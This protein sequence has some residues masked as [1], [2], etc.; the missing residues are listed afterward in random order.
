MFQEQT[1]SS[2]LIKN[3][4]NSNLKNY[5]YQLGSQSV[6]G[7]EGNFVL[8]FF[9]FDQPSQ[10]VFLFHSLRRLLPRDRSSKCKN[11]FCNR[12]KFTPRLSPV[13]FVRQLLRKK[14]QFVKCSLTK[15]CAITT[16][17][18]LLDQEQ[19]KK[20][21]KQTN[22]ERLIEIWKKTNIE[23]LHLTPVLLPS[24]NT[25]MRPIMSSYLNQDHI[26]SSFPMKS[27][28]RLEGPDRK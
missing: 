11:F 16:R 19:E 7:R 5:S 13:F 23:L 1:W 8:V 4:Y 9:F 24:I 15:H 26:V 20:T 22:D 2:R 18:S 27:G 25:K 17:L 10:E 14:L 21:G 28:S 12:I 3:F 6:A